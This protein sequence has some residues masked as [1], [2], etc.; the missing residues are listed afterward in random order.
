MLAYRVK[1][2]LNLL[3]R[4]ILNTDKQY[5]DNMNNIVSVIWG[6]WVDKN[7]KVDLTGTTEICV[8]IKIL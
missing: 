7:W 5:I 8:S 6:F 2:K 1:C 4:L 3:N